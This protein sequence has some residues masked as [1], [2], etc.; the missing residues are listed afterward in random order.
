MLKYPVRMNEID[1]NALGV[2][3]SYAGRHGARAAPRPCA[4]QA[5]RGVTPPGREGE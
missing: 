3:S 4:A 2:P 5:T 1:V